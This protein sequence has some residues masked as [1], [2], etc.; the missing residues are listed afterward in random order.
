MSSATQMVDQLDRYNDELAQLNRG[1]EDASAANLREMS[2]AIQGMQRAM[3]QRFASIEVRE[4]RCWL[5][6]RLFPVSVNNRGC[7]EK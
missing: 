1:D 7:H 5:V 2:T 6:S 3:S 4:V